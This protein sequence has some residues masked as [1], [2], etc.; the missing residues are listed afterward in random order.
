MQREEKISRKK[1]FRMICVLGG[2]SHIK[3]AGFL[4]LW[5]IEKISWKL[6][7]WRKIHKSFKNCSDMFANKGRTLLSPHSIIITNGHYD[8][9]HLLRL[10]L[11]RHKKVNSSKF[12]C[13]SLAKKERKLQQKTR[14]IALWETK[15]GRKMENFIFSTGIYHSRKRFNGR[16]EG[17]VTNN[18]NS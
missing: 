4:R 9:T 5:N 2:K 7:K 12:L 6:I 14:S 13:F 10:W 17:Y 16:V 8:Q 1:S 3:N 11:R 18:L 15:D